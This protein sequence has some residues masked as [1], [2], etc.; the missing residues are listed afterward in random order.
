[1]TQTFVS[2]LLSFSRGRIVVGPDRA[3]SA[4]RWTWLAT[5][6]AAWP[7]TVRCRRLERVLTTTNSRLPAAS[8]WPP[9][10]TNVRRSTVLVWPGEQQ[11]D[12][13]STKPLTLWVILLPKS[14]APINQ[15]CWSLLYG[16]ENYGHFVYD[17]F[18][19]LDSSATT[20]TVHPLDISPM[21]HFVH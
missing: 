15:M 1:M 13:V 21:R 3:T 6:C 14:R 2:L 10:A 12:V 19:P 11:N 16:L 9:T 20:W 4:D 7:T 5:S 18:R 8:L 17:T